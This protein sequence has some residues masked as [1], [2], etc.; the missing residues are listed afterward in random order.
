V[1]KLW[2]ER[3]RKEWQNNKMHFTLVISPGDD[4]GSVDAL[5]IDPKSP[6]EESWAWIREPQLKVLDLPYT[7][8]VNTIDLGDLK[9]IHPIDK[10]PIAQR[11]AL[12]VA[13]YT[14]NPLGVNFNVNNQNV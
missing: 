10:C 3:Y 9:N 5:N 13:K 12:Q 7:S 11:F 6:T 8:I 2:I 14:L 1:L 4:I